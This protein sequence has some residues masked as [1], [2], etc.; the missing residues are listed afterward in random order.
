MRDYPFE[1][2][3]PE[4]QDAGGYTEIQ[5]KDVHKAG[6][7][8]RTGKRITMNVPLGVKGDAL[9]QRAEEAIKAQLADRQEGEDPQE[10]MAEAQEVDWQEVG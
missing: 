9:W 7:R 4:Q 6:K 8:T 1:E 5:I 2:W 3:P 10:D